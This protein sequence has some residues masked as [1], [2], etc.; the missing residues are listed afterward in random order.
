MPEAGEG[1]TTGADSGAVAGLTASD[2]AVADLAVGAAGIITTA[3][4][5]GQR[6]RFP[7][8]SAENLI[9]CLHILQRTE[10]ASMRCHSTRRFAGVSI[11]SAFY[12]PE[13]LA[14]T[15]VAQTV[16]SVS[17]SFLPTA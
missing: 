15:F 1:L 8:F 12:E 10:I 16:A 11:V 17:G 6:A 2:F 9:V 4:H 5:L 7:A 13:A 3:S 14:T